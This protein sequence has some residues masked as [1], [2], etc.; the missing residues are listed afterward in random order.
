MRYQMS[1]AELKQAI[2]YY[3]N[4]KVLR[5]PVKVTEVSPQDETRRGQNYVL[6][7]VVTDEG[8]LDDK[9]RAIGA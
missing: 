3:L 7:V 1:Q 2:E 5:N 9:L 8:A 4:E 6:H